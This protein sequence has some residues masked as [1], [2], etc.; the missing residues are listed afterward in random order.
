MQ[1]NAYSLFEIFLS[2]EHTVETI[3]SIL[4]IFEETPN[5]STDIVFLNKFLSKY[6][7][8]KTIQS[9]KNVPNER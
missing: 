2:K 3:L 8:V 4:K 5:I 9:S 1:F 7:R 6:N